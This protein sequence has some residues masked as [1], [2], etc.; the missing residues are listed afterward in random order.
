MA[1]CPTTEKSVWRQAA[2][3]LKSLKGAINN[4]RV[5]NIPEG[6]T[7]ARTEA[8]R[9]L[10]LYRLVGSTKRTKCVTHVGPLV[11]SRRARGFHNRCHSSTALRVKWHVT[12][13]AS[14]ARAACG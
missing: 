8:Y 6:A 1:V 5:T 3:G 14:C 11:L 4:T 9:G 7:V 2:W 12:A 10:G 13:I